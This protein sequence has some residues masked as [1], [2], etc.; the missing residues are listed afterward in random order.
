LTDLWNKDA[1]AS[2]LEPHYCNAVD[3]LTRREVFAKSDVAVVIALHA[4]EIERL[5]GTLMEIAGET[6]F[7]G[8]DP[9]AIARAA[10]RL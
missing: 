6:H 5:T 9:V 1:D 10:L 2:K 7:S 4:R 3:L 8:D